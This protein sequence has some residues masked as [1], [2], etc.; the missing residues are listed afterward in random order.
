MHEARECRAAQYGMIPND[1][2]RSQISILVKYGEVYFQRVVMGNASWQ[3]LQPISVTRSGNVVTVRF[4][5][6]NPPL[7][8]DTALPLPHQSALT[9]WRNGRGFELR[10]G[11][12][13]RT[14]NSVQIVHDGQWRRTAVYTDA[15][16]A[17]IE[18]FDT[19]EIDLA[20]L[21]AYTALPTGA[22]ED[23]AQYAYDSP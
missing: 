1:S 13:P 4:H 19:I 17:R 6:P 3:P 20:K 11:T 14:V 22:S 2:P 23:P 5:I 15:D 16:R 12:T 10:V 18:P 7:A 9:Q 21:W 8:W